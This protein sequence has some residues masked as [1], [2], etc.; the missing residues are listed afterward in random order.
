[1]IIP[2]DLRARTEAAILRI[3]SGQAAMRVPVDPTDPDVVLAEWL[4]VSAAP[5]PPAGENVEFD[6]LAHDHVLA[7]CRGAAARCTEQH[8]Y[9]Q[10]AKT[11]PKNWF[12]HKWVIGA[13]RD[14]IG[15]NRATC[16]NLRGE[17]DALHQR[18][19]K[20]DQRIDDL[21]S[22]LTKAQE[23]LNKLLDEDEGIPAAQEA[24][25]G[26][27]WHALHRAQNL[28]RAFLTRQSA[29][30]AKLEPVHG[31]VLPPVG[32]KVHVELGSSG[33]HEQT[34][35]GYYAW[36]SHGLDKNLHRVFVRVVDDQG[37]QNARLLADVRLVA[38]AEENEHPLC[39]LCLDKKTVPGPKPGDFV[40][41]CPDCCGE[42]G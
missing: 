41:D 8:T 16:S 15:I 25:S 36:P 42:E 10:G 17:R 30:A 27:V 3:T 4:R 12:P 35:T 9:M 34:V 29:P 5:V 40:R 19:N 26:F 31:D 24:S 37:T 32:S 18:L 21:Q 2:E 13:I 23:L 6:R 20:A 11:D 22:E 7:I 28:I 39:L 33:W 14:L 38:P 1:M